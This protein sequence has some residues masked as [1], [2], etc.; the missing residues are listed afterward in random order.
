MSRSAAVLPAPLHAPMSASRTARC[1]RPG[2]CPY[3]CRHA[4]ACAPPGAPAVSARRTREPATAARRRAAR[5]PAYGLATLPERASLHKS[6]KL[7]A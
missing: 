3:A 4:S 5:R 7:L 6:G 1:A 2:A